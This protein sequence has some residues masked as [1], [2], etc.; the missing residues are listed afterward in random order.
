MQHESYIAL[1]LKILEEDNR[2]IFRA[3]RLA[4]EAFEFLVVHQQSEQKA[5]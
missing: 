3:S 1:W 5:A 2:A 4:R